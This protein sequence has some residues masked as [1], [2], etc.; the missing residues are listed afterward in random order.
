MLE[1]SEMQPTYKDAFGE[2]G[3]N[4]AERTPRRSVSATNAVDRHVGT[5]MRER[6]TVL[7]LSQ[8]QLA[9]MIGVTYQ[10]AH[11]YECGANRISAGRL[12][13]VAEA[14]AVPVSWFFEGLS[15]NADR[16][17]APRQRL[18]LELARNFAAIDNEKHQE[19]LNQMARL[20]ATQSVLQS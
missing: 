20:L 13:D 5:R 8:H 10:Q 1:L 17:I 2:H 4:R 16:D 12:F 9:G 6:R 7:G 19:A 15:A 11:K 18:A 3:S 14:L